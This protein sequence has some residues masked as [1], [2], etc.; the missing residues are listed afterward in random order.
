VLP[1]FEVPA[2]AL[3]SII[4]A[5]VIGFVPAMIWTGVRAGA[6]WHQVRC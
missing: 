4:I 1:A 3:R 6:L 5:L 2:W